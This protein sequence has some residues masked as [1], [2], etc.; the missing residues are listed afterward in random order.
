MVWDLEVS[1]SISCWNWV[2]ANK[3]NPSFV[4]YSLGN[5]SIYIF[6]ASYAFGGVIFLLL[7]ENIY[8]RF[9]NFLAMVEY[10]ILLLD[11]NFSGICKLSIITF[12]TYTYFLEEDIFFPHGIFEDTSYFD[13]IIILRKVILSVCV[14][15]EGEFL[16]WGSWYKVTL[17]QLGKSIILA[18]CMPYTQ[19]KKVKYVSMTSNLARNEGF[20][21]AGGGSWIECSTQ[22][23]KFYP[24]T[25]I[26]FCQLLFWNLLWIID[27]VF[28][29]VA[30]SLVI[31]FVVLYFWIL[32]HIWS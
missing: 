23:D 7:T 15:S 5:A 6:F 24:S 28:N 1:G 30:I 12:E 14:W 26:W 4:V 25:S 16:T 32:L 19:T 17:N 21:F 10:C 8:L 29:M 9:S 2:L 11:E 31:D 18:Y 22:Y 27:Y 20:N 13:S 3:D